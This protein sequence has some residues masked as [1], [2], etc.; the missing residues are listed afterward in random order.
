VI[1]ILLNSVARIIL[2]PALMVAIYLLGRGH[3]QP[4]G[5]FIAGLVTAAAFLLQFVAAGRAR[6][7]R[8]LPFRPDVLIALGLAL[9]AFTGLGAQAFGWPFLTSTWGHVD[10]PLLGH[11]ETSTAVVFDLGV[12]LVVTG[13]TL[14]I[15]LGIEE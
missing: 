12:Y 14:R 5:G 10:V 8:V 15:L 13:V 6:V 1:S 3:H 9:A 11:L 4:G 7:A 2:P